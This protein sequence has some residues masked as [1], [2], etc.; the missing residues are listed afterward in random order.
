[1]LPD[2]TAFVSTSYLTTV[3]IVWLGGEGTNVDVMSE[4]SQLY[5]AMRVEFPKRDQCH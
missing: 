2:S 4:T 5:F 1:L 3:F